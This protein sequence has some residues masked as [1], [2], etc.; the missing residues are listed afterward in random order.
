MDQV[1]TPPALLWFRRQLRLH[2]Q[3]LFEVFDPDQPV[4]GVFILDPREHLAEIDGSPRT[5]SNRMRFLLESV[6]EFRTALASL[7]VELLI[8]VG[9]PESVLPELV[10]R[11]IRSRAESVDRLGVQSDDLL[12]ARGPRADR[13]GHL[14]HSTTREAAERREQSAIFLQP[15]AGR[16]KAFSARTG[17]PNAGMQVST[18]GGVLL[19]FSG[20]MADARPVGEWGLQFQISSGGSSGIPGRSD[21]VAPSIWANGV[22]SP[23]N[24]RSHRGMMSLRAKGSEKG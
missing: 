1:T 15:E 9:H 6:A 3:P 18:E 19:T 14:H 8:R 11:L 13:S 2:D 10:D 21:G 22:N 5:G 16:S 7:G 20:G 24:L 23:W 17:K 4:C 12:P